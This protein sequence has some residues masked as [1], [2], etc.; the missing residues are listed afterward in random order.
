MVHIEQ[1]MWPTDP[2][3]VKLRNM[4]ETEMWVFKER[5]YKGLAKARSRPERFE[6]NQVARSGLYYT[7]FEDNADTRFGVWTNGNPESSWCYITELK[8]I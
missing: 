5:L 8:K 2:N 7:I 3:K 6:G 4:T 1:V